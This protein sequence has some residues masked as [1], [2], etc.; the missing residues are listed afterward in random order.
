MESKVRAGIWVLCLLPLGMLVFAVFTNGLG[1]DPAEKIMH[2]TGEWSLRLLLL[3]LLISPLRQWTRWAPI[4]R[5]RR[6]LGLCTFLYACI[7]LLCFGHFFLGWTFSIL[8]EELLER[9]YIAAGFAAWLLMLPLAITSTRAMQR[10]LRKNWTKLHRAVY[11][12]LAIACIQ[13]VWQT[14]SDYG[15]ALI[16]AVLGAALLGWRLRRY[17]LRKHATGSV[18]SA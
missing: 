12:A 10:R 7:H 5:W 13:V 6:V 14:R 9:P 3:T 16:Y 2:V 8:V 15:E 18:S 17:L 11:G 1:P 4:I